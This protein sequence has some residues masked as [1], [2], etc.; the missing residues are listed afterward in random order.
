MTLHRL[1]LTHCYGLGRSKW[2]VI[3]L[4]DEVLARPNANL[5]LLLYMRL[6]SVKDC[7]VEI[8]GEFRKQ[9]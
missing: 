1:I 3:M 9:A 5:I 7:F 6:N 8:R 4:L 2:F